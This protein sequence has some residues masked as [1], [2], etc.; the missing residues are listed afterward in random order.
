MSPS[1][2]C[3]ATCDARGRGAAAELALRL[4]RSVQTAAASQRTEHGHAALPTRTP[5]AVLLGTDRGDGGD[6][7]GHRFARPWGALTPALSQ[8]EREEFRGL[9]MVTSPAIVRVELVQASLARRFDPSLSAQLRVNRGMRSTR[10]ASTGLRARSA[11]HR[12]S[13]SRRTSP[14]PSKGEGEGTGKEQRAK[15]KGQRAKPN[16]HPPNPGFTPSPPGRGQG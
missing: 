2:C 5:P 16:D 8:G 12:A 10:A 1:L 11:Q 3:G 13:T 15:G 6:D 4:W 14:S 7:S 9:L